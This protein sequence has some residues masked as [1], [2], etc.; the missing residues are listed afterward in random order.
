VTQLI[1]THSSDQHEILRNIATL[2]C[3]G[4]FDLDPTYSKGGF[5]KHGVPEPRLKYDLVPQTP[6]T[7]QADCRDLPLKSASVRSVVFDPPFLHATGK[8]SVMGRRFADLRSQRKLRVLY[9]GGL[10]EFHRVLKPGGI[11]VFKCQDTIESGEQVM[12]H[13]LVWEMAKDLGFVV[14]DLFVLLAKTRLIGYNHHD[15]QHARKFHSYFWVFQKGT[16]KMKGAVPQR[17]LQSEAQLTVA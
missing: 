2:Y 8:A 15:Q 1:T 11:L 13:C 10:V 5:Y 9:L 17:E 3:G 12:N 7:E 6:D 16:K 4:E 14:L